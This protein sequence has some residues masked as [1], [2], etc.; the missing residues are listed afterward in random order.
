VSGEKLVEIP[1]HNGTVN[2]VVFHPQG[3]KVLSGSWDGTTRMWN[4]ADG[5]ELFRAPA[6]PRAYDSLAISP[7]GDLFA[8]GQPF[9]AEIQLLSVTSGQPQVM[10]VGIA[11]RAST[12]AFAA[13]GQLLA[14]GG[15]KG[16][17]ALWDLRRQS[18]LWTVR[19]AGEQREI[20]S[21]TFSP[22]GTLIATVGKTLSV[23]DVGT[24]KRRFTLQ[25]PS[26]AF[27]VR[28]TPDGQRIVAGCV[29][30][31]IKFWATESGEPVY[32]LSGHEGRVYSLA[33]SPDGRRL[34]TTG[35]A[36][37]V[38]IWDSEQGLR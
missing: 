8:K 30:S 17:I 1:A 34:A 18:Q 12:V 26:L 21:I 24:G 33:F 37:A 2:S 11:E 14:S 29:D 5:R 4:V 9:S 36:G 15:E 27:C 23:W 13:D 20:R 22:D 6:G 32:T 35:D 7:R 3:D 28:F 10:L 38:F 19:D 31:T 16:E 25:D